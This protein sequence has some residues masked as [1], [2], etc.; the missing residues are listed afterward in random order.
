VRLPPVSGKLL[1]DDQGSDT[2]MDQD[3]LFPGLALPPRRRGA[4]EDFDK[5]D[6]EEQLEVME[7]WFRAH[8]EDPAERT[9]YESAEGG[10]IWV[11]GGPYDPHE[12]LY[13]EFSGQVAEDAIEELAKKLTSEMPEWAPV[14]DEDFYKER[15]WDFLGAN[16]DAL[17][18]YREALA[19][20]DQ[21]LATLPG[22]VAP[23][24]FPLLFAN[25][26]TSVEVYLFDTF[27]NAVLG[28]PLLLRRFVE[29]TDEFQKR[30]VRY[31]DIFSHTESAPAAV[32][33]Y[34]V[35]VLW[36]NIAKVKRMYQDALQIDLGDVG[37]LGR[38]IAVRHDIVHRN[39]RTTDDR[40][41][42]IANPEVRNALRIARQLE[43]RVEGQHYER[44]A[45]RDDAP[46][47][48]PPF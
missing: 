9:P 32:K 24:V 31:S 39:G 8:Y 16:R 36:H 11:G 44:Y 34:L 18:T 19:G 43:E 42:A 7:S 5:V 33:E 40:R 25:V 12:V 41:V 45:P 38:A 1:G 30:Q 22:D 28:D 35:G 10:Y 20:I 29:T 47:G 26:I 37:D 46:E 4:W 14:P 17:A 15:Y 6:R 3:E 2:F 48:G 23:R 21:V 27:A 13:G